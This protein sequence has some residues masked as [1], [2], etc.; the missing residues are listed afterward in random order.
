M[1]AIS[2]WT[3]SCSWT[4]ARGWRDS[5]DK[6]NIVFHTPCAVLRPGSVEDIQRMIRY[7]R[8]YDLKVATRGQTHT[9]FGQS[10]S[11]GLVIE[12]DFAQPHPLHPGQ[13]HRPVVPDHGGKEHHD[14]EQHQ[15]DVNER[16]DVDVGLQGYLFDSGPS[17]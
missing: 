9:M 6:G 15:H 16:R 12:A 4:M 1:G 2:P 17:P 8:R 14:D 3:A 7:C 11:P 10:L 13:R 5:R